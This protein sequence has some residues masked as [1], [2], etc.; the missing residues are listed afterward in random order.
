MTMTQW[1]EKHLEQLKR[2]GKIR[3]YDN[4]GKGF[5]SDKGSGQAK[6][7]SSKALDWLAWNLPF[8]CNEHALTLEKEWKFCD[9]RGWRFDWAI[10]SVKI[11]I[12]Y[13]GGIFMAK[14]G[15][16]NVDGMLKDSEKYNRAVVL[17]WR[18]IRITALNYTTVLKQLNELIN[19]KD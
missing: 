4:R 10:P 18:V 2:S 7:T 14:S 6:R 9:G 17:G 11:A 5:S 12:E 1:N 19:G 16:T 13:E 8:W 3:G 15:H